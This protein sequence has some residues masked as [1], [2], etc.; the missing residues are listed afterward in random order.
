MGDHGAMKEQPGIALL[1]SAVCL[2]GFVFCLVAYYPGL[3]SPD[4][5][6]MF[7]QARD[8]SFTDWHAT[9]M[10]LLWAGLHR[11]SPGPQGM[12]ILLLALYWGATFVLAGAAARIERRVAPTMLIAGFMPFTINFAG[13]LWS[14]VLTA[15]SW[16]MCAALGFFAAVRGQAQPIVGQIAREDVRRPTREAWPS[17]EGRTET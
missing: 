5:I 9:M 16:L 1:N 15:T 3:L 13:T 8:L 17:L 14:D 7:S 6:I 2:S 4:S 10:P 12:L 11:L